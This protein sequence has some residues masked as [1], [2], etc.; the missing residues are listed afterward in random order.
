MR[1]VLLT[2]LSLLLVAALLAGCDPRPLLDLLANQAA[3]GARTAAPTSMPEVEYEVMD[4]GL[5][6]Y[7]SAM[8]M[9][10]VNGAAF[11]PMPD[12]NTE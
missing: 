4:D 7:E 12:F 3:K 6:L 1:K 11:M 8:P 5:A 2:L 10:A 9:M